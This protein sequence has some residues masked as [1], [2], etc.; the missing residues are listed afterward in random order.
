V[1]L[2]SHHPSP[3]SLRRRLSYSSWEWLG[4]FSSPRWRRMIIIPLDRVWAS[5]RW[6]VSCCFRPWSRVDIEPSW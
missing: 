1:Y 2:L 6:P 4:R 5:S 3:F